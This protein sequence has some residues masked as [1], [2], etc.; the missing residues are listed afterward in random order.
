MEGEEKQERENRAM[1]GGN[2]TLFPL[3]DKPALALLRIIEE[4]G[5]RRGKIVS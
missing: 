4:G 3:S 2:T 5:S 1:H